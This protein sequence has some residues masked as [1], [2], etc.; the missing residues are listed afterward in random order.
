[1]VSFACCFSHQDYITI[2]CPLPKHDEPSENKENTQVLTRSYRGVE[3]E[4]IQDANFALN[5]AR[6]RSNSSSYAAGLKDFKTKFE[7]IETEPVFE[8]SIHGAQP[9]SPTSTHSDSQ[10][11]DSIE[12]VN[13]LSSESSVDEDEKA[14]VKKE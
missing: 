4:E 2:I 6:R 8:E 12:K 7:A 14:T 5:N 11:A 10:F 13:T 9:G 3:G 1:M